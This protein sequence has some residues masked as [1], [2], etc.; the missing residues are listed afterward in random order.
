M[1]SGGEQSGQVLIDLVEASDQRPKAAASFYNE[2]PEIAFGR[3]QLFAAL[4]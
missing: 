4:S 2:P 3:K 1:T